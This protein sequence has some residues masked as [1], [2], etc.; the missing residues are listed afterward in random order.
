MLEHD[1]SMSRQTTSLWIFAYEQ[2]C[3]TSLGQKPA[4]AL[5]KLL[6]PFSCPPGDTAKTAFEYSVL[7]SIPGPISFLLLGITQIA[8]LFSVPSILGHSILQ[9]RRTF[10]EGIINL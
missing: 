9:L 1:C 2:P 10:V 4:K 5:K 7:S 8:S 3:L 6:K